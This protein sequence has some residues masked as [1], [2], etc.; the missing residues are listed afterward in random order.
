MF[1]AALL[2]IMYE[3]TEIAEFYLGA[4][5]SSLTFFVFVTEFSRNQDIIVR[6]A[7]IKEIK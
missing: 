2:G 3:A 7:E 4:T 1:F 5:T 6:D